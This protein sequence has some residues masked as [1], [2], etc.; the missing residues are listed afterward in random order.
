MPL[1][2]CL[3]LQRR[4]SRRLLNREAVIRSIE[5]TDLYDCQQWASELHGEM[6]RLTFVQQLSVVSSCQLMVGLHGSGLVNTIFLQPGSVAIDL[7]PHNYLEL[8]WH[9]FASKAGVRFF[10]MFLGDGATRKNTC[11]GHIFETSKIKCRSVMHQDHQL[12]DFKLLQ[13][14]VAQAD[15]HVRVSPNIRDMAQNVSYCAGASRGDNPLL[16][17]EQLK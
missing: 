11:S 3:V 8:E 6:E 9:N 1:G 17:P 12:E 13:V 15:F 10:F 7:L 4:K 2:R 16:L 14:L 5:E